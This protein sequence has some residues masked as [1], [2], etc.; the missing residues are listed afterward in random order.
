MVVNASRCIGCSANCW[1]SGSL[2][3]LFDDLSGF[4]QSP[5]FDVLARGSCASRFVRTRRLPLPHLVGS[6]LSQRAQ[7]QQL[8]L[9]SFFA[10]LNG[11]TALVCHVS[12]RAFAQ[13][14]A[15]LDPAALTAL[16]S[17]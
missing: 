13:A 11:S 4:I 2:P 17:A 12:D 8:M 16:T 6:L 3:S 10:H 15:R 14:R 9:D 1:L 5:D 7:S